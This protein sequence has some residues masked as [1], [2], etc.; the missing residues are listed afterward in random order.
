MEKPLISVVMGVYNPPSYNVLK[1]AIDSVLNQTYENIEFIICDDGSNVETKQW[2]A[3][4]VQIDQR[5]RCIDNSTNIGLAATLNR[6]IQVSKG[7]YIARQDADDYSHTERLERQL[8]FLQQNHNVGY[9]GS[10]IYYFDKYG[11]WGEFRYPEYPMNQD[12]MWGTSFCHGSVMF[13]KDVLIANGCYRVSK[14]TRRC[15][16]YD[17]FMRTYVNGYKA[18][19]LQKKL[20]YFCEDE[21]SIKRRKF[22][23][24]I[25]EVKIRIKYFGKLGLYPKG[26]FYLLKPV[27]VGLIPIKLLNMMKDVVYQRKK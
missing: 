19:N 26:F 7:E 5:I 16:D 4:I 22:I 12:F 2:L 8:H 21:A 25:Y 14:E 24:R 27:V 17:L 18:A 9:V 15:E 1:R 11:I 3:E 10:D 20:Y 23:D 13:R 6:C